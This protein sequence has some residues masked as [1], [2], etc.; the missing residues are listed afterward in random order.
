VFVSR[1]EGCSGVVSEWER[2]VLPLLESS[3]GGKEAARTAW[4]SITKHVVG[5]DCDAAMASL[6]ESFG[7]DKD[8][9]AALNLPPIPPPP[10][11]AGSG[12]A[13]PD[14]AAWPLTPLEAAASV[15]IPLSDLARRIKKVPPFA[16]SLPA[17]PPAHCVGADQ[18]IKLCEM[19]EMFMSKGAAGGGDGRGDDEARHNRAK[20]QIV[21]ACLSLIRANLEWMALDHAPKPKGENMAAAAAAAPAVSPATATAPAP[22]AGDMKRVEALVRSIAI[23]GVHGCEGAQ[24]EAQ[25][26]HIAGAPLFFKEGGS[27]VESVWQVLCD[28]R[29]RRGGDGA[30]QVCAGMLWRL[31]TPQEM[32]ACLNEVEKDKMAAERMIKVMSEMSEIMFK[33]ISEDV[34]LKG[35]EAFADRSSVKIE[36]TSASVPWVWGQRHTRSTRLSNGGKTVRKN[37]SR[38]DYS[39]IF[40]SCG[41]IRH[42]VYEWELTMDTCERANIGVC[43]PTQLIV[44]AIKHS[45]G[46]AWCWYSHGTMC[47]PQVE[48]GE[49]NVAQSWEAGGYESGDV[50]TMRLHMAEETLTFFKNGEKKGTLNRVVGQVVPF[51]CFDNEGEQ[52]TITK[53]SEECEWENGHDTKHLSLTCSRALR[54]TMLLLLG[55]TDKTP[56]S[57]SLQVWSAIVLSN[58]IRGGF[59]PK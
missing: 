11:S 59:T 38:P 20:G 51:V 6:V 21:S 42:G 31:G 5:G 56:I 49:S 46:G 12:L 35:D 39:T 17:P 24:E 27:L 23:E 53:A 47:G 9:V 28:V 14:P 19:L 33:G 8:L 13:I 55:M 41:A 30:R 16:Q 7:G 18:L 45:R 2:L 54:C 48:V 40:M 29:D 57:P 15:L 10:S 44:D 58:G 26:A 22:A 52:A 50:I 36:S 37:S 32:W 43:S 3:Q 1:Q 34:L 25:K 4:E